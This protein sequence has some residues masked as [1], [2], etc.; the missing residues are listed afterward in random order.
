MLGRLR[1][2]DGDRWV[3]R[4]RTRKTGELLAFL[5]C[6]SDKVHSREIL[7]EMLFPDLEPGAAR[8]NLSKSISF[9]RTQFE[10]GRESP[11]ALITAD[12]FT[13]GLRRD[14]VVTDV[15]E[16]FDLE[17]RLAAAED[18]VSR[19]TLLMQAIAL[20]H[21]PLLPDIDS[22]WA[23][24]LRTLLAERRHESLRN[25]VRILARSGDLPRSI[26]YAQQA[27]ALDPLREQSHRDLMTLYISAGRRSDAVR[28]Y[29][30]LESGLRDDLGVA[31]S[32][33]S[34]RLYQQLLPIDGASA[35]AITPGSKDVDLSLAQT[36]DR[37]L[38]LPME[39][40]AASHERIQLSMRPHTTGTITFLLVDYPGI[41]RGEVEQRIR[42]EIRRS[43]GGELRSDSGVLTA[44]FARASDAVRC[45]ISIRI[46]LPEVKVRCA[47]DTRDIVQKD[48]REP[49]QFLQT[50]RNVLD[51]SH[52]GQSVCTESVAV[53]V[54]LEPDNACDL[55][56]LGEYRV[57][58]DDGP[59]R[60]F[61]VSRT[62]DLTSF[63]PLNALRWVRRALPD[64]GSEIVGRAA[65]MRELIAL[66]QRSDVRLVTIAGPGG[67]G[68]TRLAIE[69]AHCLADQGFSSTWWTPL[70]D[71]TDGALI[72]NAVLDSIGART[73]VRR[74]PVEQLATLTSAQPMLVFLDN[75]EHLLETGLTIVNT[76]LEQAP[77]LKLVTT[78]RTVLG[79][80]REHL[81]VVGPLGLPPAEDR[82]RRTANEAASAP[83]VVLFVDRARRVRPDFRLSDRNANAVSELCRMLDGIPLAIELAASRLQVSSP[84]QLLEQVRSGYDS[85]RTT[86][87]DIPQRSRTYRA[88]MEWGY[89][90][91]PEDL[92]QVF[93]RLSVFRGDWDADAA[94]YICGAAE[95]ADRASDSMPVASGEFSE[96]IRCLQ[97]RS[98]VIARYADDGTRFRILEPIRQFGE[99][100]LDQAGETSAVR[101]R[102]YRWYE[103][104]AV[105]ARSHM[106]GRDQNLWFERVTSELSN[107]RAAITWSI[108][109]PDPAVGPTLAHALGRY[110]EMRGKAREGEQWLTRLLDKEGLSPA[111]RADCLRWQGWLAAKIGNTDTA[112]SRLEEALAIYR[113]LADPALTGAT[114]ALLGTMRY[115][116]SD[117]QAARVLL[118]E[119]IEIQAATGEVWRSAST[120]LSIGNIAWQ[121]EK[122]DEAQE[123]WMAALQG[124]RKTGD[125]LGASASMSN[126]GILAMTRGAHETAVAYHTEALAIRREM[127][128]PWAIA[129][130]FENLADAACACNNF[131]DAA[132]LFAE[133][134]RIKQEIDD[135]VGVAI[136]LEAIG[137]CAIQLDHATE[138]VVLFGAADAL[139]TTNKIPQS[140]WDQ[141]H[142][143][144]VVEQAQA[145]MSVWEYG[146]AF[147]L[148]KSLGPDRT[149]DRATRLARSLQ[150]RN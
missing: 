139:R 146:M 110:W 36:A 95:L 88:A 59:V 72:P 119:A 79:L 41:R 5:A 12:R 109:N 128:E 32:I 90:L 39:A 102:H 108:G 80:Q 142:N 103:Q 55:D 75:L 101:Y 56:L 37:Q 85:L 3:S 52:P 31:P 23:D 123:A 78:S 143:A 107:V 43:G 86:S 117:L 30:A 94:A 54:R 4:F 69:C 97:E 26:S 47:L 93:M 134:L 35:T 22:S 138:G 89:A 96:Q 33:A 137:R 2:H 150:A 68:K 1:V 15:S 111:N 76:M 19:A 147:D 51:A 11:S 28:Q 133:T 83:S 40:R 66:I 8:N 18:D 48:G 16:F 62:D 50:V 112:V 65:E 77:G 98:L 136:A 87:R 74:D 27:V 132:G 105:L 38:P 118:S 120:M 124:Q 115:W 125:L 106:I 70:A 45:A 24:G 92:Q 99:S 7:I 91:M 67:I 129:D 20:H 57:G 126:L 145:A 29:R 9:L 13:V 49:S 114:L 127:N 44:L 122:L 34:Q 6:N 141:R 140:P 81:F 17:T 84:A 42:A 61:N 60:L 71:L 63:P 113:E 135:S 64:R 46:A 116:Q 121:E 130:S 144:P 148:G 25:L 149:I 100:M 53:L 58:L 131:S 104:L 82:E 73:S 10:C 14:A 21:G